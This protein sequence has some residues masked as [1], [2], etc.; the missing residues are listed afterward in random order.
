[1]A[2]LLLS[3][4][5]VAGLFQQYGAGVGQADFP[6][7]AESPVQVPDQLF[8]E[9]RRFQ[10]VLLAFQEQKVPAVSAPHSRP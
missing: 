3:P 7:A 9:A 6:E 8:V 5:V 4:R 1:M 10:K 2:K